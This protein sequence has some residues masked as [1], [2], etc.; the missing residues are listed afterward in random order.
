ML[1]VLYD[2]DLR[3]LATRKRK[4]RANEGLAAGMD[5]I[6]DTIGSLFDHAAQYRR[7]LAGIGVGY[8]GQ[9][10]SAHGIALET[11]NLGWRNVR[12]RK[13]LENAFSVPVLLANDVDAGTFGEASFGAG[14]KARC[15]LGVFPGTGIGGACIYEGV[16]L[17]G[18]TGSCMEIGHLP[19]LPGGPL[20]GCGQYGCLEAVAGRLAIAAAAAKAVYRGRAP[21]LQELAG[22]DI[23]A[24]RS[25]VLA[26]AI[27][28]GDT[29]VETIVRDAARWIGV[30]VAA[31]VNLLAPDV[32]VLGGGLVAAM[33]DI[34]VTEVDQV[35]RRRA[36]PGLCAR[37]R[38]CGAKLGDSA[39]VKGAA[40]LV[41]RSLRPDTRART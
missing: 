38:V 24:M 39:T 5:R 19:V 18:S 6:V 15:V 3:V 32:V 14:R 30:G 11:P 25:S 26:A 9:I 41:R 1:A 31:A 34:Y 10:D 29:V 27:E 22:T 16:I 21:H 28:A 13:R 2:D 12:L 40:A 20:C 4:T 7:H 17:Q 37:L 33:P 35:A 8:P 36:M 23:A